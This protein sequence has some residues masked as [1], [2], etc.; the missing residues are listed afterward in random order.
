MAQ[1]KH[2]SALVEDAGQIAAL[3]APIRIEILSTIEAMDGAVTVAELAE[4]LGRPADG[5]YYHLRALVR[6]G[7]LHEIAAAGIRR[8]RSTVSPGERTRLRYTPGATANARAVGRVAAG[9]S[10][11]SQRDFERALNSKESVAEGLSRELW[12]ARI[13]GWV[14]EADLKRI[15]HHLGQ[16]VDLL[17]RR[18]QPDAA[19]KLVALHW[20]LAPID[21]RSMRRQASTQGR[22]RRGKA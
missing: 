1:I 12:V 5:L 3:A 20:I 7:L 8:F 6:G 22:S 18:K 4:R 21:A 13:R 17:H 9:M 14:D 11:L 10:R 19:R 15:N 16:I 2:R